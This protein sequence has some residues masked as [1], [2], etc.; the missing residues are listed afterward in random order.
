VIVLHFL[1]INVMSKVCKIFDFLCVILIKDLFL[2]H[3]VFYCR[4]NLDVNSIKKSWSIVLIVLLGMM[5]FMIILFV[6]FL[7]PL[8]A[9]ICKFEFY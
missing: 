8:N 2:L 7:G 3:S 9:M 6:V 1:V 4:E 5:C